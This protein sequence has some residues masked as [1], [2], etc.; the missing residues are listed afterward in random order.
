MDPSQ[1]TTTLDAV[2][3]AS[4]DRPVRIQDVDTQQPFWQWSMLAQAL[5]PVLLAQQSRVVAIT[6]SQGS[7][8]ST[9]AKILVQ[10]PM[11][12]AS[13]CKSPDDFGSVKEMRGAG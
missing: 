5:A 1:L 3:G 4:L 13:C 2:L 9:L 11:I 12:W 6:G 10:Q 8:K 7:G